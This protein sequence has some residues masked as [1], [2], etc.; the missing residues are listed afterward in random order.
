MSSESK[1][2]FSIGICAYNEE[3][4]IGKLLSAILKQKLQDNV[5]LKE[6]II[7]SSACVDKTEEIVKEFQKKDRR[8]KLFSE[9]KRRG[10]VVAV[11][12][13]LRNATTKNLV[14]QS[15]DTLPGKDTYTKMI[16]V[17]REK[18]IG[19]VGVKII[20]LN[21]KDSFMGFM[22]H[23]L[24]NLHNKINLQFPE[25]AKVGEAVA[26]KKI[27]K[28][29]PPDAIVDEASIEP[30]IHGQGYRV[31]YCPQAV[32]YNKGPETIRDFIRQRRRNYAGHTAIKKRFGYTVVTYSNLRIMGTLIANID[33]GNW[34]YFLY[35]PL[36]IFL[37]SV[38]RIM[39]FLDFKFSLRNH[40]SWKMARTTKNLSAS[41][42]K[43]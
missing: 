16:S 7:I 9:K 23:L 36:I 3:G 19:M 2:T 30:L 29:I 20:P 26:F 32:V 35:V 17:L 42:V 18:D 27:F 28:R 15:A 34:R 6:I 40:A 12:K 4:N 13:F 11:N 25:R 37:E 22:A 14:L 1:K 33:W 10:K 41:K 38:C 31:A 43:K 39:G 5:V 24:W 21:D 8:I